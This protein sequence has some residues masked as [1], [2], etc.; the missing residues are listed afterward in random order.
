[1]LNVEIFQQEN[2]K[3]YVFEIKNLISCPED[4]YQ[5]LYLKTLFNLVEFIQSID[6]LDQQLK[7]AITALKLRRGVL[8]PKNAGTEKISAEEAQWTYALFSAALL[9]DLYLLQDNNNLDIIIASILPDTALKWLT[10]NGYL[11]NQWQEAISNQSAANN[12]IEKIIKLAAEKNST[13]LPVQEKLYSTKQIN[14]DFIAYLL[15][16]AQ[17]NPED[18]LKIK[19]GL[20]IS[21]DLIDNFLLQNKLLSK[22]VFIQS[23]EK[24]NWLILD[25]D[26]KYHVITPKQLHD[27]RTLHGIVL[28]NEILPET[29]Q[30]LPINDYFQKQIAL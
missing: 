3:S 12:E 10:Q 22:V 28:N 15:K 1:M 24:N 14:D 6:F 20:F 4:I 23:L 13:A 16:Y 17:E 26:A 7:L 27:R 2:F 9:K 21:T 19:S 29:L 30:N 5:E 25:N 11:F 18:I 8:F